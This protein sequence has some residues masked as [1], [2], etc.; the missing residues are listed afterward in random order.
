MNIL[1]LGALGHL[2]T[3]FIISQSKH[4]EVIVGVDR[5]SY[6]SQKK[7]LVENHLTKFIQGDFTKVNLFDLIIW[8]DIDL[9]LNAAGSTHVDRSYTHQDEFI[10]DNIVAVE[11]LMQTMAKLPNCRLIHLS[12]DEV[13]GDNYE[14]PRKETDMLQPTNF[15]SATKA[16]GDMIIQSNIKAYNMTNV[17]VLRPNNLTGSHQY[18]DKV[19]PLFTKQIING[20]TIKVHDFGTQRRC[21][22]STLFVCDII[23]ELFYRSYRWPEDN[24]FINVGYVDQTGV[25]VLELVTILQKKIK[26]YDSNLEF[27]KGRIYNDK[28]YMV[29]TYKLRKLLHDSPLISHF[30]NTSI[31][32]I[33]QI[34]N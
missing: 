25:S 32:A 15:Y 18:P 20:E 8:N 34:K 14:S 13:Y 5:V 6:C 16:S 27:V 7:S 33:N 30:N 2:G 23:S 21:F 9:V 10:H 24:P 3:N 31:E 12:T 17:L 19:I 4:Y 26:K 28:H 29:C 1:V 22:I 11:Y